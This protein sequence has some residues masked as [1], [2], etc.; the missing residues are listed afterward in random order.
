MFNLC[1][2]VDY[3]TSV[4]MQVVLRGIIFIINALWE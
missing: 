2:L 4:L 1:E 3:I